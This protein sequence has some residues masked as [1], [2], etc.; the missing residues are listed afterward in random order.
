MMSCAPPG[1]TIGRLH[2]RVPAGDGWSAEG[3]CGAALRALDLD[4]PGMPAHGILCVRALHDPLPAGIDVR[5]RAAAPPLAWQS[6]ARAALAGALGRAARPGRGVVVGAA[7]AVFFAD[8][9]ELLAC[10]ARDAASGLLGRHW[11]WEQLLRQRSLADVVAL[12]RRQAV[13]VPAAVERLGEGSGDALVAFARLLRPADAVGLLEAVG[14]TFGVQPFAAAIVQALRRATAT[15]HAR[16]VRARERTVEDAVAHAPA[17]AAPSE[18]PVPA[19]WRPFASVPLQSSGWSDETLAFAS[20]CLMLRAAPGIVRT[21]S[22]QRRVVTFFSQ[23][24]L[25][26][27][28]EWR[29]SVTSEGA[30]S[31]LPSERVVTDRARRVTLPLPEPEHRTSETVDRQQQSLSPPPDDQRRR[32]RGADV[33]VRRAGATQP[34][35][36]LRQPAKTTSRERARAAAPAPAPVGSRDPVTS[37]PPVL[38]NEEA[39]QDVSTP[40]DFAGVFFLINAAADLELHNTGFAFRPEPPFI[41][42][43]LLRAA[44]LAAAREQ[45][46]RDPVCGLLETLATN[47]YGARRRASRAA[48]VKRALTRVR[49]HVR[50]ALDVEDP[51]ATLVCQPGRFVRTA[52]HLDV[53]F[54]LARH[55]IAIRA[56]RFDRNPGWIPAAGLHVAFVFV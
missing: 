15:H 37:P 17:A 34:T 23:R 31:T 11:W 22:F 9:V 35:A 47:S 14:A 29:G 28:S 56:A 39:H 44:G 26:A 19:P 49:A 45:F 36:K 43:D 46:E 1:T 4:P 20:V 30:S 3:R 32:Q 48:R 7:D 27:S 21:E 8:E 5:A 51:I 12:W 13:A 25:A 50:S 53:T 52:L 16:H 38:P 54:S 42:W 2:V 6:A 10:A 33:Q 41:L 40:S 24:R 55:P 18:A